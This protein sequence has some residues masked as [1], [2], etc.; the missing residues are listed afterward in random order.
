MTPDDIERYA[1]HLMLKE[2]GGPGQAALT[3]A[4]VAIVGAGG[5]GG[6]AGLYLAAAGIGHITLIDDD[7]VD[8]SNLQRQ[9][10]FGSD[11]IGTPKTKAMAAQMQRINPNVSVT[12]HA[13]RLNDGNADALLSGHDIILDGTDSFETR[14]IIAKAARTLGIPLMSGAIG[15]FNGQA[16]LFLPGDGPCYRCL[17]PEAPE[18]AQSC[19][20]VGVIGALAG[21]VGS[22]MALETIK[23]MAGA[24]QTLAGRLWIYDGL[25]A[26]SRTVNLP[27]DPDCPY[28]D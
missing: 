7:C 28:H 17:V 26:E 3:T 18:G 15:R 1:R 6:P 20:E 8:L 16:A 24:G 25:H 4:R 23:F 11:D 21:I 22:V 9:I 27:R 19:A 13:H 12:E 10:Q 14:F 2:V 5:L